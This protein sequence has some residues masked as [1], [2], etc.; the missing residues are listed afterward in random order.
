MKKFSPV[1]L[2]AAFLALVWAIYYANFGGAPSK[3]PG[4]WGVFGDYTGGVL[5]PLLNFITIYLLIKSLNFQEKQIEIARSEAEEARNDLAE[6]R[7]NEALR[8]YESSLLTFAQVAI[9]EYKS[10]SLPGPDGSIL[11]GGQ[12]VSHLQNSLLSTE[13]SKEEFDKLINE[14][15]QNNHECIYSLTRSFCALFKLTIDIC[16][17]QERGRYIDMISLIIPTKA[18][19]LLF[20]VEAY[21]D[22]RILEHPRKLGFFEREANRDAVN[23]MKSLITVK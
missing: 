9:D 11:K 12:A 13:R 17:E 19:F 6:A 3:N 7:R 22:W 16:P 15:D 23:A 8:S 14:I 18:Q 20:M 5:N 10:F 2:A 1:I 4:N 21:S